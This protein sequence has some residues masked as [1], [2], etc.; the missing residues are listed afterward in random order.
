MR[1][2]CPAHLILLDFIIAT[3][4]G[5]KYTIRSSSLCRFLQPP[6]ISTLS[7]ANILLSTLVLSFLQSKTLKGSLQ[8]DWLILRLFNDALS[9]AKFTDRSAVMIEHKHNAKKGIL[10][11]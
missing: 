5:D 9:A 6:I 3:I 1:A 4:Y 10:G 2:A 7:G 8:A 11:V